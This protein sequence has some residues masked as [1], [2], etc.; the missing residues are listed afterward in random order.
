MSGNVATRDSPGNRIH[1]TASAWLGCHP[2]WLKPI[3]SLIMANA[4]LRPNRKATSA[5]MPKFRERFGVSRI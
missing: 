1:A 5:W 4:A 3:L 2:A